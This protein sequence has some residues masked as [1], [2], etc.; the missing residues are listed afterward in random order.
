MPQSRHMSV[1]GWFIYT[2]EHVGDK[3]KSESVTV[4]IKP[5]IFVW[6]AGWTGGGGGRDGSLSHGSETPSN[7][8]MD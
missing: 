2:G 6:I 7:P 8:L 4:Y 5:M 1:S 3:D